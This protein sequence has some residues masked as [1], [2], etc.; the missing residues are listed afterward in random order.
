MDKIFFVF[1]AIILFVFYANFVLAAQNS[2]T[3]Q[4]Q[5]KSLLRQIID[6]LK[7]ILSI[8]LGQIKNSSVQVQSNA[9][10]ALLTVNA[11]GVTAFV[12]IN[13]GVPF[14][15]AS[16]IYLQNGDTYSVSA[17]NS[18]CSGIASTGGN[19]TCNISV[20]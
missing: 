9:G 6:L 8:K 5:I 11:K 18:K 15:Y 19:Y 10:Q 7:Q 14:A 2:L 1:L 3:V 4:Q 13:G 20:Y 16:P 17:A 12:S